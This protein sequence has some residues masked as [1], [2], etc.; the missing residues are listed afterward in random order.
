MQL[1]FEAAPYF[2]IIT[3]LVCCT[4]KGD[5]F[6]WGRAAREMPCIQQK[7]LRCKAP[8]AFC[9]YL[10]FRRYGLLASLLHRENGLADGTGRTADHK[11]GLALHLKTGG[12]RTGLIDDRHV[13]AVEKRG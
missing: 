1:R 3:L 10:C 12:V 2:C 8:G 6:R 4:L 5:A 11:I 9:R 7:A 13:G